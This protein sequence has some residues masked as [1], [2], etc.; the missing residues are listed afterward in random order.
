MN[1]VP[2]AAGILL[3]GADRLKEITLAKCSH[4]REVMFLAYGSG[5]IWIAASPDRPVPRG[6]RSDRWNNYAVGSSQHQN[7]RRQKRRRQLNA[8]TNR[9]APY[10]RASG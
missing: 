5:G 2:Q 8:H 10:E 4:R 7:M 1:N 9:W 6:R 3:R